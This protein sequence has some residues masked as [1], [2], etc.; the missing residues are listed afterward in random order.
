MLGACV[1]Y[2]VLLQDSR[3]HSASDASPLTRN[4][5]HTYVFQNGLGQNPHYHGTV[6]S[7]TSGIDL[8][9]ITWNEER[10]D[11]EGMTDSWTEKLGLL[12]GRLTLCWESSATYSLEPQRVD[13]VRE[14]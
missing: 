2:L 7:M 5:I 4:G 3:L 13:F 6:L 10:S 8:A 11:T 14:K 1:T 12:G 9:L